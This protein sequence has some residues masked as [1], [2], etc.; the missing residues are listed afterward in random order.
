MQLLNKV[1]SPEQ[2]ATFSSC[3]QWQHLHH[4]S[5][6]NQNLG[7][8]LPVFAGAVTA[9]AQGIL[10]SIELRASE[11]DEPSKSIAAAKHFLECITGLATFICYN[12]PLETLGTLAH[13]HQGS[14]NTSNFNIR[15]AACKHE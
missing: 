2:V 9:R 6:L 11:N 13:Y 8:L 10:Q 3:I 7:E 14:L 12:F 4:L 5:L 15:D 1:I